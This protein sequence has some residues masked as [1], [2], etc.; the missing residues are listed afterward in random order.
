M[1]LILMHRLSALVAGIDRRSDDDT[2]GAI[3]MAMRRVIE[4]RQQTI[5]TLHI[6]D[7][8]QKRIGTVLG[9]PPVHLL[10]VGIFVRVWANLSS[11]CRAEHCVDTMLL[12][13]DIEADDLAI[14]AG[15]ARGRGLALAIGSRH[16]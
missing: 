8:D 15:I 10:N 6:V 14:P 5:S 3:V 1:V 4:N 13:N 11:A 2:R 12:V 9:V 7:G 16:A